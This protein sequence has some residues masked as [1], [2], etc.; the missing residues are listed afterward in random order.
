M[1]KR[2]QGP[3]KV[4]PLSKPVPEASDKVEKKPSQAPTRPNVKAEIRLHKYIANSGACPRRVDSFYIYAF[5]FNGYAI[6][7][8]AMGSSLNPGHVVYL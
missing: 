4:K 6:P 2:A 5:P 8:L 7:R 3:Y 1:Q